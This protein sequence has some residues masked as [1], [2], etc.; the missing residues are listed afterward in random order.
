MRIESGK[1]IDLRSAKIGKLE[2][3]SGASRMRMVGRLEER[4]KEKK[5]KKKKGK[6]GG[7]PPSIGGT[8]ISLPFLRLAATLVLVNFTSRS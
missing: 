4:G 5:K 1:R 8:L 3:Q 2:V 7:E 6:N